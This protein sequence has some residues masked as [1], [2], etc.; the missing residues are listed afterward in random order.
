[1]AGVENTVSGVSHGN[2]VQA[3]SIGTLHVH[4]GSPGKP[5]PQQLP[6]APRLFVSRADE[7]TVLDRWR[8]RE[9]QQLLVVVSGPGGIGKTSLALRWLH[10][11]RDQFPD[12]QLYVDL[13]AH[14][15]MAQPDEVLECFL[16]ALGV[17]VVPPD[18]PQRQ[19][20]FRSLTADRRL[21]LL[22][23]NAASAA[24]VRPLLPASPSCVVVVTS[25]WRLSPLGMDGA[26]F[27]EVDPMNLRDSVELLGRVLGEPRLAE[28]AEAAR[29][30]AR[31]CGG[32]PIALGVIG[33]RLSRRPR[34][35]LAKEVD[36]LSAENRRLAGLALGES[37]SV[38]AVL[39][40]SY[41]D[42]PSR[43]AR[44]YRLSSWH[45]GDSFG[46]EAV[47]AMLADDIGEVEDDLDDL[48]EKNLLNEVGDDRFQFHDL[49]RLHAR[50][51]DDSERDDA[52]QRVVEFYLDKAVVADAAAI[53]GRPRVGVRFKDA[54]PSAFGSRAEALDWLDHE[55]D[56]LVQAL[57]AADDHGW[58]YL[59]WQ[60]AEAMYALFQRRHHYSDW[61]L[62]HELGVS[63]A[64]A[65]GERT[66]EARLR[67]QLAVAFRNL[68]RLDDAAEQVRVVL[69]LAGDH[70]LG[71]RATA[72]VLLGH[73]H[74]LRGEFDLALRY[75]REGVDVETRHG[76]LRGIGLARRRV[77]EV[78]VDMGR[79]DEAIT[80][81]QESEELLD[82]VID[83]A[84]ARMFLARAVLHA[85]RP[86]EATSLAEG[87]LADV[88]DAGSPLH[89][90]DTFE[91]LGE[92]AE[93]R[94][95]PVRARDHYGSALAC[96]GES[97]D[98]G[99][100]RVRHRLAALDRHDDERTPDVVPQQR[101]RDRESGLC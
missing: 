3:G 74:R 99:A 54:D 62:T 7:L 29:E 76:R 30:L 38:S 49:L 16:G 100:D 75:F 31:L 25:R 97:F 34:R 39:D 83:K 60:L 95:D 4:S 86:D 77:G 51:Q 18:L 57:K 92:I 10:D 28:E 73:V 96:Y 59:V 42:L 36:E 8:E 80:E 41:V 37:A 89:V 55:R 22:L 17:E 26:R 87:V 98:P 50:G 72:L 9:D 21:A 79:L 32:L 69:D 70:D 65:C 53:P 91:L 47:A 5:V 56:N 11:T 19:A 6:P 63:A 93:R 27:I 45:P 61:L 44:L 24:Q 14:A 33:A 66:A 58:P 13:G 40:L 43:Q 1:M 71:S 64:Q 48:V 68:G 35:T 20:L 101:P 23:D 67:N 2:V 82:N 94:G 81:L 46:V 78:L 12:G 85:G 15:E 88:R 90:A 52:I 84:R